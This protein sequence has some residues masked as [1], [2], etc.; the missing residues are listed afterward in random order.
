MDVALCRNVALLGNL[1]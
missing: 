1:G